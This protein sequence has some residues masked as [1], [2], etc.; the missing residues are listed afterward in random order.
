M[1]FIVPIIEMILKLVLDDLRTLFEN[2]PPEITPA[3]HINIKKYIVDG[4]I[5]VYNMLCCSLA[6]PI[7][8]FFAMFP[9]AVLQVGPL[10]L[11]LV[12]I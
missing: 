4:R 8:K 2:R 7:A 1:Q 3:L 11:T 10:K 12:S 9:T 6:G 5:R